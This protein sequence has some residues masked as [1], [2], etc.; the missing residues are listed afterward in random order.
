MTPIF[1][2]SLPRSGST[3]LQRLLLGGGECSSLGEPSL[4]LRLLGDDQAMDRRAVYW[5]FLVTK[6]KRDMQERW[7]GFDEAYYT[8]VRELMYRIY[9]GLSD[10][11]LHH[12]VAPDPSGH[13]AHYRAEAAADRE[14]WRR[15]PKAD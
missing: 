7:A 2:L 13:R 8:G 1:I 10:G 12:P 14:Q 6:A 5:D 11:V 9:G 15:L 4:L 3:L